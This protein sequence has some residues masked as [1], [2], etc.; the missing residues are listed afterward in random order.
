MF[1]TSVDS[2]DYFRRRGCSTSW[3]QLAAEILESFK[4]M[5]YQKMEAIV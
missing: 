3:F 4:Y 1:Q 2:F 5:L